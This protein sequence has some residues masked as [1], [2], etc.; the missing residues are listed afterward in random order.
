MRSL[1]AS[2]LL[3]YGV[4]GEDESGFLQGTVSV[5]FPH[6]ERHPHRLRHPA[7]RIPTLATKKLHLL[8]KHR[9]FASFRNSALILVDEVVLSHFVFHK[10]HN[11]KS[12]PCRT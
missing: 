11:R 2:K 4:L 5:T 3:N 9:D 1:V 7:S 6:S 10:Q 12:R 8:T